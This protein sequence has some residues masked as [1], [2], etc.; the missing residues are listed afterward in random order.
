MQIASYDAPTDRLVA[1]DLES[2]QVVGS[3]R[4]LAPRDALRAGGNVAARDFDL[5]LLIVLRERL[6]EIDEP[7]VDPRYPAGAIVAS[8]LA[9]LAR[10]LIA[11]RFDHVLATAVVSTRDGG[12]VA[13][14]LHRQAWVRSM[15]PDDYRVFPRQ[16]LPLERLSDTRAVAAPPFL[17][18]LLDHGAWLC[19]DPAD[20]PWRERAAFPLLLPLARM[21]ERHARRFLD[22]A[23]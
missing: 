16:R 18:A 10:Y 17:K 23:A 13:A 19:G 15:S 6:V 5:A 14:S 4:L 7:W 1:R 20:D 8:L 9:G 21:Q 2:G 12:H 22:A 11:N 3:C